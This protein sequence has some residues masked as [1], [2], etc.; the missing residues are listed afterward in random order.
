MSRRQSRLDGRRLFER[1]S[2]SWVSPLR[3]RASPLSISFTAAVD[4]PV[5][6]KNATRR[7]EKYFGSSV[8]TSRSGACPRAAA[9]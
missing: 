4:E 2:R 8:S 9:L 1:L 5:D 3:L 7:C 6:V